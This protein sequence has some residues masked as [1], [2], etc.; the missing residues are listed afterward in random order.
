[1]LKKKLNSLLT[2]VYNL[3]YNYIQYKVLYTFSKI[4]FSHI[5]NHLNQLDNLKTEQYEELLQL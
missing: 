3:L 2:L 4:C 5:M 1:M